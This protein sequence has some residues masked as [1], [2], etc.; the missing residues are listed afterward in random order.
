MPPCE[1]PD[2]LR[3]KTERAGACTM[4]WPSLKISEIR[5]RV[6]NGK[7]GFSW[8]FLKWG[9]D[10]QRVGMGLVLNVAALLFVVIRLLH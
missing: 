10:C 3:F 1:K 4:T 7:V 2:L 8:L 9:G 5:A 6:C